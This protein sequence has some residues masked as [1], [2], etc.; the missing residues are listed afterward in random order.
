MKI[1]IINRQNIRKPNNSRIKAIMNFLM[2]E[3]MPESANTCRVE[4]SLLLTNDENIRKIKRHFFDIDCVTDVISFSS[5][6][7][8]SG[9]MRRTAELVVNVERAC[10]EGKKRHGFDH[11]FALYLAHGCDHLAGHDDRTI[12]ERNKMRRR[13]LLWLKKAARLR[14]LSGLFSPASKRNS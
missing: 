8:P 3:A 13:E 11:E 4:L 9:D 12:R 6:P 10:L 5:Q 7:L 2:A 1:N 14:L